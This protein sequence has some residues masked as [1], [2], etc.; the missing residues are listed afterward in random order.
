LS[1]FVFKYRGL[2]WGIFAFA[3]VIFPD[4]ASPLRLALAAPFLVCGQAVRFWAAGVIPKY[5]TLVLDA[6]VLV[7]WGPY[8]F[9]R[10]PL[11]AGNA[12]LGCGWSLMAGPFWLPVFAVAYF[13]I[14]SLVII[15]YEERFLL[16]KFQDEYAS[17]RSVTPAMVPNILKFGECAARKAGEFDAKKSWS[18][19]RHSLRMNAAVTAV[20][21]ARLAF[22]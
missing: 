8:A 2:L 12:L 6:P 9:I 10:N 1:A 15:P 11:Y 19:E 4:D 7:T 5:R 16:K 14:Y 21:L 13:A 18:M 20:I 22:L 3:V 17:Y